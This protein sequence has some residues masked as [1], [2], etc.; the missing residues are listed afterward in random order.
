MEVYLKS[1]PP[2]DLDSTINSVWSNWTE[3]SQR[4]KAGQEAAIT[5]A[6]QVLANQFQSDLNEALPTDLQTQLNL[7]INSSF[8]VDDISADFEFMEHQ[9]SIQRVW[10]GDYMYWRIFRA[11]E[12]IDCHGDNLRNQL[13]TEFQKIK[14]QLNS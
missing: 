2:K 4:L 5:E 6:L 10:I 8:I 7:K 14:T 12:A 3:R 13:L 11:G 1:P 9:F